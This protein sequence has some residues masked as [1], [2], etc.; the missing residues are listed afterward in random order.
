MVEVTSIFPRESFV[1]S[2]ELILEIFKNPAMSLDHSLCI[3]KSSVYGLS[4]G[5]ITEA[6]GGESLTGFQVCL[7]SQGLTLL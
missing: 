3:S 5:D 6:L 1:D 7:S 4:P 2:V